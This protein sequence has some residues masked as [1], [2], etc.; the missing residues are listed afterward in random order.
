MRAAIYARESLNRGDESSTLER[1]DELCR[2]YANA[3]GWEVVGVFQE[4]LAPNRSRQYT[5]AGGTGSGPVRRVDCWHVGGDPR[6]DG[7]SVRPGCCGVTLT[8]SAERSTSVAVGRK[9]GS[10]K[11][12]RLPPETGRCPHPLHWSPLRR[13]R[14]TRWSLGFHLASGGPDLDARELVFRLVDGHRCV[15]CFVR[16]NAYHHIHDY[17]L[18]RDGTTEGTPAWRLSVLDPLVSHSVA[19]PERDT[20][21][22]K[23]SQLCRRQAQGE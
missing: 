6:R 16:I 1:Q 15:R 11:A 9:G 13:A 12:R 17:R 23:A 21:R 7:R 2:Q 8:R 18:G 5:V 3:S 14:R 19:K 4:L 20:L 22:T 10:W